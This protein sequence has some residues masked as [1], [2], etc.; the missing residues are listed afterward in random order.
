MKI[1][2]ETIT[3]K[4]SVLTLRAPETQD[5][6]ILL[7]FLKKVSGETPYLIS[8]EEEVNIPLQK[9]ISFRHCAFEQVYRSWHRYYFNGQTGK[10]CHK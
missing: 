4:D 7:D 1:S 9:E 6:M 8:T 3:I 5:A 10:Y 2:K